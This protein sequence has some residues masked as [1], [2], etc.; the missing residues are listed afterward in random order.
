MDEQVIEYLKRYHS[1][2]INAVTSR[3]L[4]RLFDLRGVE[5]RKLVN[6]LRRKG[7][8]VCSCTQG[9]YCAATGEELTHTIRQ[10]LSRS[11]EI[12]A[13]ATGMMKAFEQYR[14]DGQ[15]SLPLTGGDES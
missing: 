7:V 8:P 5:V 1:G 2:E 13:A 10:L 12:T 15:L 4:E 3:E 11:R 14:D 9:Y 6:R